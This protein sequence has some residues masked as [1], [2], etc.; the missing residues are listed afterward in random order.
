MEKD[1][2]AKVEKGPEQFRSCLYPSL[3]GQE[4][5]EMIATENI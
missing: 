2:N 1:T 3:H 5:E 4:R